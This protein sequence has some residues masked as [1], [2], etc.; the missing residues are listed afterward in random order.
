MQLKKK[1][2]KSVFEK[3]KFQISETHHKMAYLF[4]EGEMILKSRLSQG[5]GDVPGN[6]TDKIRGQL[7]LNQDQFRDAV[8]CPLDY[9][10]YITILKEK[11]IIS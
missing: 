2:V 9:D 7:Y 5:S 6:I 4:Y 10:S 1:E 3:F 8:Q 11:G